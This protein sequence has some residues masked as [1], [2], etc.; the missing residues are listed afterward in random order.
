MGVFFQVGGI[1][2][3]QRFGYLNRNKVFCLLFFFNIRIFFIIL[4]DDDVRKDELYGYVG[5]GL[6]W[7][8]GI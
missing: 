7:C 1:D 3:K 2:V 4:D 6:Y 8:M 5:K